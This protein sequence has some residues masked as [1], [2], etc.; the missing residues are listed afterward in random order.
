MT[1]EIRWL[2]MPWEEVSAHISRKVAM[3][4]RLMMVMYRFD[5]YQSWPEETHE[6]E[7]G[8]YILKG[9]IEL[10]LP[11]A[12]KKILLGPGDGY[13]I[14]TN[15]PHSWKTAGEETVLLDVFSPPRKE[16][17]QK[18]FAPRAKE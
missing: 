12:G 3:K 16:L 17:F 15:V 4:D 1:E 9:K 8:G 11:A 18:K 5:P 2:A 7:Q 13:L 6:A 10:S 14:G